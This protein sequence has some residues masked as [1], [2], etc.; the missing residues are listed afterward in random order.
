MIAGTR[1]RG[2]S[3]LETVASVAVLVLLATAAIPGVLR[4]VE[5]REEAACRA[6][7]DAIGEGLRAFWRD[8]GRFPTNDEGLAALLADPGTGRWRGPYLRPAEPG[9]DP[10]VDPRGDRFAYSAAADEARVTPPGFPA[11]ARTILPGAAAFERVGRAGMEL[12]LV[13]AA[14]ERWRAAHGSWPASFSDLA[15][16]LGADLRTDPWGH[17]Y[18][19]DTDHQVPFSVGPDG[20]AGTGDDIYPPGWDPDAVPAA[21]DPPA[22]GG[23]GGGSSGSDITPEDELWEEIQ[24]QQAAYQREM[25]LYHESLADPTKT[26]EERFDHLGRYL[27]HVHRWSGLW[28]RYWRTRW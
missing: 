17:A 20:V 25:R 8:H 9:Q 27:Y 24:R 5:A 16:E 22:G 28:T 21:E 6:R 19:L 1:E 7:L 14:A 11:L 15:A 10:L 4:L 3:L 12:A 18:R 13:A 26:W 2:A 23:G